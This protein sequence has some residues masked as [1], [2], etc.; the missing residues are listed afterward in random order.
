MTAAGVAAIAPFQM[1]GRGKDDVGT[2]VVEVLRS[3]LFGIFGIAR[4]ALVF[5]LSATHYQKS[6]ALAAAG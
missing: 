4:C 3:K 2:F 6:D 1:I 5:E